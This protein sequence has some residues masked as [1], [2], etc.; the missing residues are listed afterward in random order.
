MQGVGEIKQ[1]TRAPDVDFTLTS[2]HAVTTAY[3]PNSIRA[4]IDQ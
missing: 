1:V 3:A 4:L 2:A